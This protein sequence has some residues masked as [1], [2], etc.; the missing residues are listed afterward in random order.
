MVERTQTWQATFKVEVVRA[1][2][3]RG[4]TRAQFVKRMTA[5]ADKGGL[6]LASTQAVYKWLNHGQISDD[7]LEQLAAFLECDYPT[8]LV[9]GRCVAKPKVGRRRD[10]P[11]REA[12]AG[13]RVTGL[14]TP[15]EIAERWRELPAPVQ[16][17]LLQQIAAYEQIA[18]VSPELNKLMFNPPVNG[19]YA[20]Y[21]ASIEK[22]QEQRRKS[23]EPRR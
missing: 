5:P 19:N 13:Y 16:G 4:L 20:Q 18:R 8:L 17:F 12:A 3:R 6:A 10:D 14:P 15:E 9:S 2:A 22:W 21:E 11:A 23:P 7:N 1:I